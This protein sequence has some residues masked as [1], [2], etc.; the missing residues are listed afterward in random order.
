MTETFGK[1]AEASLRQQRIDD[2][3]S[4][5]DQSLY[6]LDPKATKFGGNDTCF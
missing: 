5:H 2:N 3:G 4:A 1:P 6:Q